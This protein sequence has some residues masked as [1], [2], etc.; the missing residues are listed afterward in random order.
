MEFLKERGIAVIGCA[1]TKLVRRS[2]FSA[3]ELAGQAFEQLMRQVPVQRERI[4]GFACT[5]AMS[6]AGNPLWSHLLIEGLGLDVKWCQATDIGGAS[7]IGNIARAAMAIQAG[8]CEMVLCISADGVSSNDRSHQVGHRTEFCDPV[9]WAGPLTGFGL[10]SDLY[11][12]RH[13]YPDHA[14]ARLAVTQRDNALLNPNASSVF[15]QA[16]TERDYLDSRVVADPLRLLDCVMRVDGATAV[17]VTRTSI[18]REL[19]IDNVVHPIAYRESNN[20][21]PTEKSGD[22]LLSGFS[23]AGPQ[24]LRDAG[25]APAQVRMFQPYD[26]FLIAILLQLEQIGFCATG[27]GG[28]FVLDTDVSR[29]GT[30]PIN[31]GGG[32]ISCG[33]PGLAGGSVNLFETLTQLLGRAGERQVAHAHNAMVTGIGIIPYARTWAASNVMIMERAQ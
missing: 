8:V 23:Q 20:F 13:G 27:Q 33:Q 30:L 2:G 22:M 25:M 12:Q 28:D 26:D 29:A 1:Q 6:E 5:L 21:D 17:L 14:L 9:G 18:A 7:N 24:A 11:R 31:T 10:L 19:G 4:D 16:L 3:Q 32:Q 15:N